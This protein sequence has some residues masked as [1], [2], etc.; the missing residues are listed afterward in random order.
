MNGLLRWKRVASVLPLR[1]FLV[2]LLVRLIPVLLAVNLGIGLDDMFQYDMLARSLVAGNGFRWYSQQDLPLI[3]PYIHL[4][5]SAVTYDSRGV[6][7]SFRAPLYPGLLA[8]VYLVAGVGP[9]RFFA[10]RLV[11]AFLGAAL[12]PLTYT[13]AHHLIPGRKRAARLSAWMI[14]LYPLL[15]LFP[16]A[17]VTENLF[18]LLVL[19][20]TVTL[21]KA[22]ENRDW[23]WFVGS[24]ILLG[25]TALTRSISLVFTGLAILWIGLILRERRMAI[26]TL[27][28]V[29]LVITPW[30]VRNS[31]LTHRLSGLENSMG[32]N[33]YVGYYPTGTGT[34]QYPQ[35]L[36]LLSIVDD[37]KREQVG[38]A[39]AWG[40]VMADPARV[41]YLIVRRAGYF[42]GLERRALTYF[43]SNDFFGYI[44]TPALLAASAVLLLPFM[45]VAVSSALGFASLRSRPETLLLALILVGYITP[46][47]LILAEDRFHLAL[48][49]FLSVLAAQ[50]WTGGAAALKERWRTKTGRMALMLASLAVLLLCLNWGWELWRD[51]GQIGLLL[52]PHGNQTYFPY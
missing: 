7:T 10:A 29:V 23:K 22:G 47:L 24:G 42:F 50:A 27:A 30:V 32:Y 37:A 1:L 33:L 4:D 12:A 13:L 39:K 26:V 3:Q 19:G 35:S 17:L 46:H 18:F 20:S 41:P 52:G 5:L 14:A 31:L 48:V 38:Y 28:A 16:L 34:F 9:R 6:L 21:L 15:V 8:L 2:A 45:I 51:A 40:F 11:Q 43:Y 44:P 25:L 49:P 36:D